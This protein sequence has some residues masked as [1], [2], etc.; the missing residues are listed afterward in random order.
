MDVFF[1]CPCGCRFEEP[2]IIS[3][4]DGYGNLAEP[5]DEVCPHCGGGSYDEYIVCEKCGKPVLEREARSLYDEDDNRFMVCEDCE[6]RYEDGQ[7][8]AAEL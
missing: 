8:D 2:R 3:Y 5:D 1:V 6:R 4:S 7:K